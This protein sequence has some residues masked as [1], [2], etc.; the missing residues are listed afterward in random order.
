MAWFS[1]GLVS[2]GTDLFAHCGVTLLVLMPPRMWLSRLGY[3]PGKLMR[4]FRG[5]CCLD[6]VIGLCSLLAWFSP[7]TSGLG[8]LVFRRPG[9]AVD[10]LVAIVC[11]FTPRT[12]FGQKGKPPG[13]LQMCPAGWVS[14]TLI[15]A[16]GQ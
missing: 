5:G 3:R 14:L 1:P 11:D 7:G 2:P 4:P 16:L 13:R 10:L 9:T 6:R 12:E 15:D 8:G